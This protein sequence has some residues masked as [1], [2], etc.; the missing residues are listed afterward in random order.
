MRTT[1][2]TTAALAAG[3][4]LLLLSGCTPRDAEP[5]PTS[6]A[7][8]D[9]SSLVA[10]LPEATTEVGEVTW[11]LVE[12]EPRTLDPAAEYSFVIPNLCESLLQ[13]QPDFTVEPGLATSAE[14]VDP[15]TFVID[16][17]EGVTF[18]DGTP[19]TPADVV[20]SMERNR[21][22]SSPWF[23][24]FVLV[25]TIEQTGD[26]QV[27]VTFTAPDSTFRDAL[28][29]AAGAVVNAAQAQQ[30]GGAFG[31]ASG[32]IL[33]TGPYELADWTPG[34]EIVTTANAEYWGGA[35]LTETLRYVFVPDG[36]TLTTALL[37]GEIDG[38]FNVAPGSRSVFEASDEGRLVLGPST[39]SFSFGPTKSTGAGANPDIRQALSLAI[40]REQYVQTVL[41][42]L[43]APQKTFTPP[44]AW[45][46]MD[47]A[48][49]YTDA[50]AALPDI[51][52][53]VEAAKALVDGSGEDLSVPLV[54]AIPAGAKELAQTAAIIQAAGAQLGLTVEI[55][56]RQPA[57]FTEIFFDPAAR[58]DIDFVATAGYLDSPGVLGYAQ[59]FLLPPDLG[60]F[61]NWSEY[62]NEAVTG[63]LQVARTTL[64]P[65][66]SADA[67]IAAQEVFAPDQLQVTLAG[68]YHLTFLNDGLT[69]ATTS[70]AA[71]SSPWALHLG[72]E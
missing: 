1:G 34:T 24:A 49:Q 17:R 66:A 65:A 6:A 27:T 8:V 47:A 35:P 11:G 7:P 36:T 30:A 41:S 29:S 63:E 22:E 58:E 50:Y 51:E 68:A 4:V 2:I 45:G 10:A 69:G 38:A 57:D 70:V 16:L 14:W 20:F 72:A 56:E 62:S 48:D 39:A 43:G 44:F 28:S 71:Y 64:D 53:D 60:G 55:D 67:F 13:L 32:G 23:P 37:E 61:F 52:F 33:C 12:G 19:L 59:Q 26:H 42:G 18:W 3:T 40:D 15:T 54:V 9:E 31:T 25:D 21:V 5:A 46:G